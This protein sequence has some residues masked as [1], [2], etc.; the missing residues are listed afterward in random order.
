ME[1]AGIKT[2]LRWERP[3]N[4]RGPKTTSHAL[5]STA[6][7]LPHLVVQIHEV[8]LEV[9]G[10]DVVLTSAAGA[11]ERKRREEE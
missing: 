7:R 10:E 5:N 11:E 9:M 1:E 3:S 2:E 8:P 4:P 6:M